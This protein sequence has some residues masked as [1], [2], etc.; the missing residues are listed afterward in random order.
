MISLI[1]FEPELQSNRH[2]RLVGFVATI[3]A[4]CWRGLADVY[5]EKVWKHSDQVSLWMRN[6]QLCFYSI[7]PALFLDVIGQDRKAIR[8]LGFFHGYNF[9]TVSVVVLQTL[10]YI[11][12]AL[13]LKYADNIMKNFATSMSIV[14][15]PVASL[16]LW[17]TSISNEL[18]VGASL[19]IVAIFWFSKA[20]LK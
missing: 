16:L 12:V 6:I 3:V 20:K 4:C 14:V 10:G 11:Q 9:A 1:N 13:V 17:G 19:V 15:S 5:F 7:L 18:L 8:E 2:S